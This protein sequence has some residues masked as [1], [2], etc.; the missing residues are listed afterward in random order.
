MGI[1]GEYHVEYPTVLIEKILIV[2]QMELLSTH[3]GEWKI[4]PH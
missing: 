4:G 1:N 3:L 2:R